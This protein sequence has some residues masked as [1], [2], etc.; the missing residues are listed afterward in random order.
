L[1]PEYYHHWA[2][3]I[4][5]GDWVG[6]PVFYGLPL[7][8]FFLALCYK[9]FNTSLLAVKIIQACLGLVTLFF[10][11]KIGERIASKR[12]GA[13]ALFLGAIYGPLFFHEGILI[14]EALSVPLYAVSFYLTLVF[15]DESTVKN[16]IIL[17]F[18]SG[19]A[20]LT[21]AGIIPF[22]FIFVGIGLFREITGLKKRILPVLS[23]LAAFLLTLAPVTVHNF[24][25]GKDTVFLTSHS[26]L[27]FYI[28]N[29]P[30]AQGV[31]AAPEGVGSNV[32]TQITDAKTVAEKETGRELK[33]SEVSRYWSDKAWDFIR[34]NPAD[35]FKLCVRKLVLFF[36]AREI[37][38]VDDYVFCGNFNP[39]LRLPWLNFA[40]LG[41]L[42][43][44][45]AI[46]S[47]RS[48]RYRFLV[49]SWIS[50]YLGG[51]LLFFVNARYRL[52]LLSIFF[53]L[54]AA[55][56]L[57]IYESIKKAAWL[58]AAIWVIVLVLSVGMTQAR[59]VGINR[60]HDYVNAGDAASKMSDV[61]LAMML[62][63]KALE[64]DPH[65][66]K[67]NQAMGVLFSRL[68]NEDKARKFYEKAL[69]EDP[70]NYQSHNNLGLWCDR[71][72]DL[73]EAKRHFL[74][75]V[76]LKPNSPQAHNNV[77]MIYGKEGENELAIKEFETSLKLDPHNAR[78]HTNLGLIL[79]RLGKIEEARNAWQL[80]LQ[81]DPEF[82]AAKRAMAL[83]K[84]R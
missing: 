39:F 6:D 16:G 22:V 27:N 54:A 8:P 56:V 13:L 65:A 10:I 7:Y 18:L 43:L 76:E 9:L 21:K 81:I 37:S 20:A 1:D 60:A 49:Y 40:I 77:G 11:Y 29:N 12:A 31:F 17:G 75:A 59:L 32:D 4:A 62:Y 45:G 78:T 79:Y 38:D 61:D 26:G 44:V 51:I 14:P 23:I 57:D 71:Q 66:V 58:K 64:I 82:E 50:S 24:I 80:A 30:K 84:N 36:D 74:K 2:Q 70:N 73:T 48:I 41:P 52:P 67:A 47:I 19:L 28:G 69:A 42:F 72:G 15:W 25:Y 55:A 53:P 46:V 35:F 83:L 33:P 3:R 34:N 63:Q 5:G 68:G